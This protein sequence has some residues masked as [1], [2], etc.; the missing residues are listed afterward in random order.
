MALVAE[1]RL[2]NAIQLAN[3]C[4]SGTVHLSTGGQGFLP[5]RTYGLYGCCGSM[6][7]NTLC[8]LLYQKKRLGNGYF[9]RATDEGLIAA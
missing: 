1:V 5:N 4:Q 8:V 2:G 3:A 9:H 7:V 6:E